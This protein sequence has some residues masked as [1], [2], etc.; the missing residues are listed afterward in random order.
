M[1]KRLAIE[2][3]DRAFL[4]EAYAYKDFFENI[5]IECA[6]VG[7]REYDV[8][9][10]DAI[11]IFHGFHPFWRSYPKYVIGEYHTLS[12]GRFSRLKDFIKRVFNVRA[13]L[14][15][16]LNERVREKLWFNPGKNRIYR[17]M[18]VPVAEYIALEGEGKHY[19]VVYAGSDRD[20]VLAAIEKLARLGLSVAVVGFDYSGDL[21]NIYSF[22]K[23]F[24]ADA[25]KIIA[26]ARFGLN[27]TPDVFP[28][29]IQDSTKVLEY[30]AA[31]L[32]VITNKYF[33]VNSFEENYDA[34]FLDVEAVS[35][36]SD[37]EQYEFKIPNIF[38][39]RLENS[40][41]R[42]WYFAA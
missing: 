20:G 17:S 40:N 33:W 9:S 24:P 32:G 21:S 1:I 39:A 10:Y 16:F 28:Y 25:R 4:P 13:D 15:I 26:S 37:V 11:L 30:C 38:F 12:T 31:G 36:K 22:G 23:V 3:S 8:K 29:N 41:F 18:G 14:N 27:Y 2:T 6:F 34:S 19:D 7:S 35:L 42:I 5:G